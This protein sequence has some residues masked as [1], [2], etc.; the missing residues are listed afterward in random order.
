MNIRLSDVGEEPQSV[1]V[2][3]GSDVIGN[4]MTG[5]RRVLSCGLVAM[6]TL[7]G[8][9][10]SGK[11][12]ENEMSSYN[13]MLVA[14]LFVKEMDISQLW[15]LDSLGIQDPSEQKS[16][17]ELHK[18][19]MEHFL[20][21]VKV[22]EEERFLVSLP[23][24]DGHLP[25]PDNFNSALKGLQVTTHKLKKENLFQE[26][27]DVFKEWKREGIIEEVP[28]EEIKS[29]CHYLPHRHVV[30][31]NSTTKIRPVF[32][33]SS[34][35]KGAV[36]LNDCL[37][38]GLN[39]IELIPS[40]LKRFRLYRFGISADI[41]KAFLQISL[42]KED[43]NFLRFLWHSEEGELIHYRHCR[44]VFGVSSS[45]FL[46]GSTI[47]YHLE[48]KLEEAQQ[49]RGRYPECIIQKLMNSFYVDNCLASFKTQSELERFID[50]AT[51][52]MAE[53]K[54]DLRGWEHSS[55]SDPI[56]NPTIILGTIWGRHCD[57]LSINIPDLR[58]LME[59]V[60]TKRNIL[61]ASHK[62]FDPLGITSP[63][64]LLPKLWLQNLWK[65]KIGWDE[66]V[67]LKTNQDFLKWLM[68]LEYLKHSKTRIAP[69]GKK[70][71][72]I[73][74]LE[75][76]GAAIS[77]RLSSTVLKE[78]PTDNVYFW[79]D[80]TT[81][82]AWLKREEPWG[83]FVYNRVQEIRKLTPVKAW[84][85]VPGSLNPVDCPSRGCSAKQL[86]SSKWWEGPSW[87]YLSSHEWPVSDVVVDVNEEEVNKE[88]S[89]RD[90]SDEYSNNR[91]KE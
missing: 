33:A 24:L 87:L 73:A 20:R 7:L 78:F 61:A 34:K 26:Y 5:Q 50:V 45:P 89:Y 27:G 57:T 2:L 41:R 10:L 23:W 19:S 85:H 47:Q 66:E 77:A 53:R 71:T 18:A 31:P 48:R 11:V 46:L 16:K 54:F 29:A 32:N 58:E 4:I 84:R 67:D 22:D 72:T 44:V 75:L 21:T 69:C 64:L 81:V 49:G 28:L 82:L 42:Y 90:L 43:R 63:V 17:V 83:V 70:E 39:L 36:S 30:K 86:C 51:E 74:R 15:R 55:P 3:L 35:Q 9:T 14:S 25:L 38:K 79:A 68:E 60:I 8:W 91:Y 88:K 76:L 59:E 80:S 40:M 52:I 62:V 56:T 65:S 13:A 6:E 1:Q 37:E 12:P